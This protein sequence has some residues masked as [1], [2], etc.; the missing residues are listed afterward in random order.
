M[1]AIDES[2]GVRDRRDKVFTT[3]VQSYAMA[4][5]LQEDPRGS[6]VGGATW[7]TMRALIRR[8][9]VEIRPDPAGPA[10]C[11]LYYL[12]DAG[13]T[14]AAASPAVREWREGWKS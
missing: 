9:M 10:Y 8:G 14:A 1:M 12:T 2:A 13:R 7:P 3:W 6:W 11:N 5:L 4:V